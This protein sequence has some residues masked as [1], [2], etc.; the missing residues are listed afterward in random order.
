VT[1]E[2]DCD[3]RDLLMEMGG[4]S[5]LS[6]LPDDSTRRSCGR[7]ALGGGGGGIDELPLPLPLPLLL[8]LGPPGSGAKLPGARGCGRDGCIV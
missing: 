3:G 5:V 1:G 4:S 8:L 7:V 6:S 2:L